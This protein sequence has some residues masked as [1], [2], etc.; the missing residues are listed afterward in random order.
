MHRRSP[1]EGA[2]KNCLG[3]STGDEQRSNL[4]SEDTSHES[5][6]KHLLAWQTE[7]GP[8]LHDKSLHLP[9]PHPPPTPFSP[10]A[11]HNTLALV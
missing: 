2:H 3:G 7:L 11:P 5:R 9:L 4:D 8:I 6:E 1:A 10:A